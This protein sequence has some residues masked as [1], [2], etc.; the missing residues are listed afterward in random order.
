[1]DTD[2]ITIHQDNNKKI[3]LNDF[4]EEDKS[5]Q[6]QSESVQS[7]ESTQQTVN[8]TQQ[9]LNQ[10]QQRQQQASQMSEANMQKIKDLQKKLHAADAQINESLKQ[11][12]NDDQIALI[13]KQLHVLYTVIAHTDGRYQYSKDYRDA[14]DTIMGLVIGGK[15]I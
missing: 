11:F 7:A 15:M 6:I 3:D 10:Q 4:V 13:N 9:Q 14:I 1:M 5:S 2:K 8:N 12:F